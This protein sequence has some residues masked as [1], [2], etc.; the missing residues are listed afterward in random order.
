MALVRSSK[1]KSKSKKVYT[2]SD[3]TKHKTYSQSDAER[4]SGSLRSEKKLIE[5][6]SGGTSSKDAP[7]SA[8]SSRL[9]YEDALRNLRSGGLTGN[10][11][12]MAE[13]SLRSSY[14]TGGATAQKEERPPREEEMSLEYPALAE[15]EPAAEEV[16]GEELAVGTL[17]QVG[18]TMQSGMLAGAFGTSGAGAP[19]STAAAGATPTQNKYAQ[20]L[21]A[22]REA[23]LPAPAD[24]G[25]AR[26]AVGSY[27]PESPDTTVV[28]TLYAE[29]PELQ[30][31]TRAAAEYFSPA[32]QRTSL[33]D[34][35]KKLRRRSGLDDINEEIIDAETILDGTEDDIR[36]EIQMAGGI[37]TE[38]QVQSMTLARNKNLLKRYNQLISM[39]EQATTELNMMMNLTAQD[40][41]MAEQRFQAQTSLMMN[42]AN[43]RQTALQNTRSQYQWMAT[44]MGADGLYSSLSKDPRQLAFA[45]KILGLSPGG[46]Q[47]IATAAA[48]EK[49]RQASMQERQIRATESN[50]AA[51]WANIALQ[52]EK[53][54]ADAR[55]LAIT[56]QNR[57]NNQLAKADNVLTK[58]GEAQGLIRGNISGGVSTG[59]L[60]SLLG[61][62]PG[63]QAYNLKKTVETV[64]ANLGF[65]ELQKMR[66][67]SPTG[68]A[69]G[70]VAIQELAALQS[71][72][73]NLDTGQDAATLRRNL[74][75]VQT[76]YV[77]WLATQ[78]Y[79]YDAASGSILPM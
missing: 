78:G 68:G 66:E 43:F 74:E 38:S 44:Q 72:V 21:A 75:Q 17:P 49:A 63:S 79:G 52:R 26:S 71:T 5:R 23:G 20:G 62:V 54:A 69:L 48:Q 46:M 34:D 67:A 24:A 37:G 73:S 77:N 29:N 65:D 6:R 35:Y 58:L 33:L 1:S 60:G 55:D 45:E 30:A 18:T 36:N 25:Q 28:D 12:R 7:V 13:A 19:V 59:A 56:Q 9:S 11:L 40:R 41:Q 31:L 10:S 47:S 61:R 2:A 15:P 22:V 70:Q 14:A 51:T 8:S 76:H 32:N 64:K 57:V 16:P 42:L 3:G 4:L 50:A 53:M 27:L 39:R